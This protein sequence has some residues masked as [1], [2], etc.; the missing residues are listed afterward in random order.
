MIK[1]PTVRTRVQIQGDPEKNKK[2]KFFKS[3]FLFSDCGS[4]LSYNGKKNE[5]FFSILG[6]IP[7]P[8]L[9]VL[10]KCIKERFSDSVY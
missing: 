3:F 1:N 2:H 8:M 7:V 6:L 4:F 9:P 5:Y 10:F